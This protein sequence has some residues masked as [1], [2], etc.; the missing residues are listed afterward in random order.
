MDIQKRF[1]DTVRKLRKEKWYSQESFA[2]TC[3]VH[4]TY[5]GLI[6]R[7]KA[8]VTLEQIQ[9]IAEVLGIEIWILLKFWK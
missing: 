6:E 1:W 4:R 8:N 9:K 2:A 5:M 3:K 7:G